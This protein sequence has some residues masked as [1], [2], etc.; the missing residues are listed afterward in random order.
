GGGPCENYDRWRRLLEVNL[1]GVVHGTQ[2]FAPAMIAHGRPGLIVNTGSKQG[3]T[4]PPGDAAYNVS[5]AAV[6]VATEQLAHELRNVPGCRVTA[7][8]LIPGFTHTGMTSRG[9]AKPDAA[10]APEQVADF[11]L[12]RLAR[13]TFYVL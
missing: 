8:L 10:W 9:A 13:G 7:H 6:K 1:W 11:L 12:E 5:K 4:T 2:I 3:I